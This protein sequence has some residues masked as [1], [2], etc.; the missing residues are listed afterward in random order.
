MR[1]LRNS[2]APISD[3]REPLGRQARDLG[4]LRGQLVPRLDAAL[5]HRLSGGLQLAL[6]ALRERSRSHLREGLVGCSQLLASIDAA[7]LAAQPLAVEQLGA[8]GLD[9]KAALTQQRDRLPVEIVCVVTLADKGTRARLDAARPRR[10]AR[11][12]L[13]AER[14]DRPAGRVGFVAANRGLHQLRQG[15][16]IEGVGV[17]LD[18]SLCPLERI[19][20]AAEAGVQRG[21]RLLGVSD[22]NALAPFGRVA[23]CSP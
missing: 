20:V 2:W 10:A 6:S 3:V 5:A 4:L 14:V 1:G 11:L 17:V 13:L 19:V 22:E 7:V 8:R 18:L 21:R 12:R 16:H 23:G 15:G 9:A